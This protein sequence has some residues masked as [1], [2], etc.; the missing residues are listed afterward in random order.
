MKMFIKKKM[1]CFFLLAI[2]LVLISGCGGNEKVKSGADDPVIDDHV[3]QVGFFNC[4]MMVACPVAYYGGIYEK[5]GL[6]VEITM[7]NQ[8]GVMMAAGQMDVGY[9]GTNAINSALNQGT[10]AKMVAFNHLGGSFYVVGSNEINSPQDLLGKRFCMDAD[11]HDVNP[12]WRIMAHNADI[13]YDPQDYEIYSMSQRDSYFALKIGEL[14]AIMVCDPWCSL[15]EYEGIG[16]E[17]MVSKKL[18]DGDWGW[19]TALMMTDGFREEHPEL[20]DKVLQAHVEAIK[21]LYTNPVESGTIF[22]AT[23]DVPEEVGL[24]TI[25]RKTVGEGRTMTW[26][27]SKSAVERYYKMAK[28]EFNMAYWQDSVS[29]EKWVDNSMQEKLDFEDFD[30]FIKEEVDPVYPLGMS[31]EEWKEKAYEMYEGAS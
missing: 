30:T 14:D 9:M 29:P 21:Y 3:I 19:K 6:N 24:L 2:F 20:A 13:S 18:T 22:S 4:D 7:T 25:Y 23:C 27:I 5:Y 15:A 10:P 28:D 12:E 31:F 1:I 11:E 26:E 16:K 8:I 17:V